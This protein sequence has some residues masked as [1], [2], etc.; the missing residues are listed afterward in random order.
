M[1]FCQFALKQNGLARRE[2]FDGREH[3]VIP[4]IAIFETVLNGLLVPGEEIERSTPGWN[5]RPI[6][7]YHPQAPAGGY[8]SANSPQI[9]S[10]SPGQL[11]NAAWEDQKLK[12]EAWFDVEKA[13]RLGGQALE[14]LQNLEAGTLTEGSTGYF[15]DVEERRGVFNGKSYMGITHNII[16]DHYAFLPDIQGACSVKDG[17]GG[18]RVNQDFS[19]GV[20]AAFYLSGMQAQTLFSQY[21]NWPKGAGVIQPR[22]MHLTLFYSGQ[23]EEMPVAEDVAMRN[24]AEFSNHM[25][26]VRATINGVAR[27]VIPGSDQHAIVAMVDSSY[28]A[29]WRRSLVYWMEDSIPI[30]RNHGFVPHITLAYVP[31]DAE[32][33]LPPPQAMEVVFDAVAL[34][35]GE[36]TTLFRLQ[37][38]DRLVTESKA[39]NGVMKFIKNL[40]Q[41]LKV[42]LFQDKTEVPQ[43]MDKKTQLISQIM[44]N[45][46]C[47]CT[48]ESLKALPEEALALMVKGL[49]PQ[50]TQPQANSTP[51]PAPVAQPQDDGKLAKLEAL[52]TN[53]AQ[54]VSLLTDNMQA[55]QD[56]AKAGVIAQ[57]LAFQDKF[58]EPELKEMSMAQLEKLL[59]LSAPTDFEGAATPFNSLVPNFSQGDN[60]MTWEEYVSQQQPAK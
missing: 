11:F 21:N 38:E 47:N 25:P 44:A 55:H 23:T 12:F 58:S 51:S 43:E 53:L 13:T 26:I 29:D 3:V 27:W 57:L 34:S 22:D 42:N 49:Q 17:C 16:P 35:W 39:Q 50:D 56:A 33:V 32:V 60:S 4:V 40:A 20:M 36:R 46:G 41:K 6:V 2:T 5:G 31:G 14:T 37:G 1:E 48:E 9:L 54:S 24:L 45:Q 30:A 8:I 15:C 59:A 28:L 19:Q 52:V 18:P 7:I 10:G